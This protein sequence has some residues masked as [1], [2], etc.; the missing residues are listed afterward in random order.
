MGYNFM[1]HLALDGGCDVNWLVNRYRTYLLHE[2]LGEKGISIGIIDL[3]CP[4][5][6]I[7]RHGV[8]LKEDIP[9]DIAEYN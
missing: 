3:I 9:I 5:P 7:I 8:R 6:Q 4:D 1:R 2:R